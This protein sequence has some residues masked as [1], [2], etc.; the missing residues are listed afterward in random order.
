MGESRRTRDVVERSQ[1][2]T[3]SM[4]VA[5]LA[6]RRADDPEL[7]DELARIRDDWTRTVARWRPTK[8][9]SR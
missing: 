9:G 4:A 8:D 7:A 5:I 2:A 6:A 1:E 3:G